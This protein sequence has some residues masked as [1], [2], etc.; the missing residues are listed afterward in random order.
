VHGQQ[1]NKSQAGLIA[2]RLEQIAFV[3][4]GGPP[5]YI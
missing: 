1:H 2:E 3:E 5:I 4:H